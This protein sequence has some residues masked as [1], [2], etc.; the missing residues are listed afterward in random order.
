MSFGDEITSFSLS[1]SPSFVKEKERTKE[2]K[3]ERERKN[4]SPQNSQEKKINEKK[5]PFNELRAVG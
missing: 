3:G 2:E 5:K 1:N 4:T